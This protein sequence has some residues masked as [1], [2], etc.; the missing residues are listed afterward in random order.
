M[1]DQPGRPGGESKANDAQRGQRRTSNARL[2]PDSTHNSIIVIAFYRA[3]IYI[4][5][6]LGDTT[7]YIPAPTPNIPRALSPSQ[8]QQHRFPTHPQDLTQPYIAAN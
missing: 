1:T 4:V 6:T 5:C 8:V 2:D 7:A 3:N